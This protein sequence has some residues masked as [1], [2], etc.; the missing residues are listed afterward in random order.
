[1]LFLVWI[2]TKK[3]RIQL[4]WSWFDAINGPC[5]VARYAVDL[6]VQTGLCLSAVGFATLLCVAILPK[7]LRIDL[8]LV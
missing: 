6:R 8:D 5:K 1:M 3:T 7:E 2:A 4:A